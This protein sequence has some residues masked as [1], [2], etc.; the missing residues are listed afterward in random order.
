[1]KGEEIIFDKGPLIP[2]VMASLSYPGF[3]TTRKINEKICVDGGVVN[4]LPIVLL[5]DADFLILIDVSEEEKRIN[6]NSNFKDVVIQSTLVMQKTIVEKSIQACNKKYVLI[7]PD[8]H[9]TGVFDFDDAVELIS[10]G[11]KEAMA[12]IDTIKRSIEELEKGVG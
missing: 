4:P 7:K 3:F 9:Y 5:K 10:K 1:M 2:A 6:E 8:V 12:V 11:E